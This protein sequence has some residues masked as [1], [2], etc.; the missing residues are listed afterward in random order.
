MSIAVRTARLIF[1]ALVFSAVL[2]LGGEPPAPAAFPQEE[3][4]SSVSAGTALSSATAGSGDASA[5]QAA[6]AENALRAGLPALAADLAR[7][8]AADKS[9]SNAERDR[10]LLTFSGAQLAAG[11]Y[12]A[13]AALLP[14]ISADSPRKRL[15]EAF[16]EIVRGR[17]EAAEA[18]L[19]DLSAEAFPPEE[20]AWFFLARALAESAL[21]KT[22][23]AEENFSSAEKAALRES[24]REHIAFVKLCAEI[25]SREDVSA[26]DLARLKARR[27]AARGTPHFAEAAKLLV[28]AL[29]KSGARAEALAAL[30]ESLPVPEKDAPDFALL[31][32]LLEEDAGSENA[33]AAFL[34]VVA[35][36][37]PRSRQAAAFSGL[38]QHVRA[39][40]NA[41]RD[42]DAV[43]AAN[44]IEKNL[45]ALPP[46]ERAHDLELFTRARIAFEVGD[47]RRAGRLAEELIS[48]FPASPLVPDAQRLLVGIAVREKEYRR[49]VPLLERL[50]TEELSP[51]ER[52]FTDIFIAD[53]NFLSG[54]YALAADAYGRVAAAGTLSGDALGAVFFQQTFSEIRN[55]DCAAAAALTDSP[56][57]ARVPAGWKMRAECAV[58]E[59]FRAE[60]LFREAAERAEKFLAQ[61]DLPDDFRVRVLW[62]RALCA[63]ELDDAATALSAAGALDS[64]AANLGGNAS[65]ALREKAPELQSRS[66]LLKARAQFLGGNDAEGLA[67][68]SALRERFPDS[69]AAAVSWLEEGRRFGETGKPA[70]ALI[71]YETLID[72][73]GS[74]EKFAEYAAIAAFEAA[75]A[76]ATIGRPDEAVKQLQTLISRYPKSPLTFYARLRQA[77]FFRILNDFD[78][79]LAVYDAVIAG[80]PDRAEMRIVEMRRADA[81]RA[82]AARAEIDGNE[83]DAAA[84][85]RSRAE[86][87]YERLFSLPDQPLSLKAEAGFK[88]GDV[89]ARDGAVSKDAA[90]RERAAAQARTIFWRAAEETLDAARERGGAAALGETGG[91]W[92]ARCYF[93][94]AASYERAGDYESARGVYGLIAEQ[95]AAGMIPGGRYAESLL[96][97]IYEK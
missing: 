12:A 14:E 73:F 42:A 4:S 67:L 9:L 94:L 18:R 82:L 72:R 20:R 33:R 93:A 62:T 90:A 40:K 53:C 50:R 81:L 26:E 16:V 51:D 89:V 86:A 55:G 58:I 23:A 32:G 21:G 96:R 91:Y 57:A 65:A 24:V 5:A 64:A 37:P 61:P 46:D 7:G 39:L 25:S 1:P 38:L 29:A 31:E 56:L 71:C 97:R 87:A 76:A 77:D 47:L 92:V 41:G 3:S 2:S 85:A 13:L 35:A 36:R 95:S 30:R 68:L 63:L 8:A 83:K 84:E 88:W 19:A 54:D 48:L 28:V 70:R 52:L 44:A 43:L 27:D 45:S 22:A 17:A 49:A 34:R 59:A 10:L 69:A 11:D 6:S 80:W 75:Q 78:S 79:A 60:G 74:Q 66:M 15:R